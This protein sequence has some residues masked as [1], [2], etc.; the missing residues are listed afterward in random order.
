MRNR[1]QKNICIIIRIKKMCNHRQYTMHKNKR[2]HVDNNLH[3]IFFNRH[4]TSNKNRHQNTHNKR[5][6]A[7]HNTT[8]NSIQ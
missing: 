1:M 4:H 6:N 7:M 5:H 8:H 2:T 3:N